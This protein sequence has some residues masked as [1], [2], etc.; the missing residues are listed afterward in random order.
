M[1]N[2]W[3]DGVLAPKRLIIRIERKVRDLTNIK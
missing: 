1:I 3:K 2:V